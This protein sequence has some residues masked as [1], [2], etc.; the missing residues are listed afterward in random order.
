MPRRRRDICTGSAC[1]R[2]CSMCWAGSSTGT[3]ME[4]IQRAG[5]CDP[6]E[7]VLFGNVPRIAAR[8]RAMLDRMGNTCGCTETWSEATDDCGEPGGL[9]QS[10]KRRFRRFCASCRSGGSGLSGCAREDALPGSACTTQCTHF[11]NR[12]G[13]LAVPEFRNCATACGVSHRFGCVGVHGDVRTTIRALGATNLG[14][15]GRGCVGREYAGCV[16]RCAQ[17]DVIVKVFDGSATAACIARWPL[18]SALGILT[19]R[20]CCKCCGTERSRRYGC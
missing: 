10:R 12:Y 17:K 11:R 4:L 7:L 2:W 15:T 19:N 1:W 14:T 9:A 5:G 3:C 13:K 6:R 8:G 18:P 20:L 16:P